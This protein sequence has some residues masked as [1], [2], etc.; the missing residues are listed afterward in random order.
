MQQIAHVGRGVERLAAASDPVFPPALI[1]K[2]RDHLLRAPDRRLERIRPFA[3]ADNWSVSRSLLLD[4]LLFAASQ[5]LV[6]IAWDLVCPGCY[7]AHEVAPSLRRIAQ[8]GQCDAC[9]EAYSR[10][11]ADSVELIFRPHREVRDLVTGVYCTGSPAMRP[12]VLVQQVLDPHEHRSVTVNLPIGQL[13]FRAEKKPATGEVLV[14]RAALSSETTVKFS[15]T[16]VDVVPAVLRPGSASITL[17]NNTDQVQVVRL[18]VAPDKSDSVTAALAVT[19]PTFRTLFSEELLAEGEHLRVGSLAFVALSAVDRARLFSQFGDAALFA[20]YRDLAALIEKQATVEQ[21]TV[22]RNGLEGTLIAFS[23]P[24]AAVRTAL[25]LIQQVKSQLPFTVRAAVHCGQCILVSRGAQVEYFGE[26]I[27]QTWALL[28]DAAPNN[29]VVSSAV[30][31]DSAALSATLSGGFERRV[32][33]SISTEYAG[34]RIT[35][36]IPTT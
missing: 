33:H 35:R 8:Q 9:G 32:A 36:L 17:V 22:F 29:I 31:S 7:V 16:A 28:A 15:D 1:D 19:H 3:L 4:L 23:T 27:E 26:T 14:S 2:L 30:D 5:S 6:D 11:L 25:S 24:A 13:Y 12:H 18:M 21:G 20:R 34:R 10:D